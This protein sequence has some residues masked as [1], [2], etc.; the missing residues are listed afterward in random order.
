MAWHDSTGYYRRVH[1]PPTT[2]SGSTSA[3][4]TANT[5][6]QLITHDR[7][8]GTAYE[9]YYV[10]RIIE[11]LADEYGVE[12]VLEGP[13]DG[14]AGVPGV[15]GAGIARGKAHVVSYV[16]TRTQADVSRG[17]FERVG[18]KNFEVRVGSAADV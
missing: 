15:H 6:G 1:A 14:M 11:R 18:A 2:A 5:P 4:P 16:P 9:R 17:V 8:L 12:S 3:A 10:Y 7:G 13:V